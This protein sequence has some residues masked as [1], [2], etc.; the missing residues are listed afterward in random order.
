MQTT[1]IS[2]LGNSNAVILP[3]P[4]MKEAKWRRGQKMTIDFVPE[5]NG[6]FIRPAKK[7]T[8]SRPQVEFQ[9]WLNTFLKED[10]ELLD[11]LANR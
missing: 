4:I 1:T 6:I 10:A 5:A 3:S 11:E 2:Q 8:S 7:T 9:E